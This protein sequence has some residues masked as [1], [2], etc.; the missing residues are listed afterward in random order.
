MFAKTEK[1][2]TILSSE[3]IKFAYILWKIS[4]FRKD[5]VDVV[6]DKT[7]RPSEHIVETH[8]LIIRLKQKQW[9]KWFI[10]FF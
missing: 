5:N 2:E 10:N 4:I 7:N 1:S 6:R 9:K 8:I 3:R